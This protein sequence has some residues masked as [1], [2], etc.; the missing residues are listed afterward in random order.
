MKL[1]AATNNGVVIAAA[2]NGNGWQVEREELRGR[3]VTS[4]MAREGVVLAGTRNGVIRSDDEGKSW[5]AP[6]D[7]IEIPHIRSLA[8]HPQLSDYEFAGAE[9]AAVFFSVDGALSWQRCPEVEEMRDR[10]G[11]RLPYSP[12]AG[13]VR[14]FAF[15]GGRAYAA[16]EDGGVLRSDDIGASWELAAGSAGPPMHDPSAGQVHSDVHSIEVHANDAQYVVAPTGGG[17]Y[18]SRDGGATWDNVY[19]RYCRAV[20]LDPADESH[21]VLGPASGVDRQGRIEE[22]HDGGATWQTLH[23]GLN[24]PWA[25]YMVERFVAYDDELFAV[26]SNGELFVATVGR[27]QWRPALPGVEGIRDVA[28]MGNRG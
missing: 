24:A 11:W 6:S 4:I 16:V 5:Q 18:V 3:E 26:L 17:L 23:E 14:G 25:R 2:T 8:Y 13:C 12:E 27:W 1:Y 9:P 22:S 15:H 7:G 10:Y 19:R 21:L 28:L 20:W